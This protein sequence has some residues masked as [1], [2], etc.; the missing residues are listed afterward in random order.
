LHNAPRRTSS[1]ISPQVLIRLQEYVK[2]LREWRLV[3]NLLSSEALDDVWFRHI[4][5]CLVLIRLA[6]EAKCWLDIGAGAGLPSVV[7]ACHLVD[8]QGACVYS[9]DSDGR[10]CV[11]L[12]EVARRLEL[13]LRV[14]NRR[15]ESLSPAE[16]WPVDVLTAR[17]FATLPKILGIA[18][19]FV[20]AGAVALLQ[21]GKTAT[22]ELDEIDNN[23]YSCESVPSMS[24]GGGT[25]FHIK[26]R[27]LASTI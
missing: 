15:A 13:P 14:Y 2:L 24:G 1:E 3:T 12:R 25:I 5:D 23:C 4:E 17:A 22:S 10:K 20:T 18:K 16:I 26:R 8:V 27:K 11:F 7:V 21:R 19:P 9:V 6:P